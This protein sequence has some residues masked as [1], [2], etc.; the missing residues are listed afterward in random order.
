MAKIRSTVFAWTRIFWVN[1]L[2]L[3][4]SKYWIPSYG[5]I[6]K[7][8]ES[9]SW[10]MIVC[11]KRLPNFGPNWAQIA[12][13]Q[14]NRISGE[15]DQ[16]YYCLPIV[17]YHAKMFQKTSWDTTLNNF[18]PN[19]GQIGHNCPFA[20]KDIFW[21]N[22]LILLSTYLALLCYIVSKKMLTVEQIMRHK[23]SQIWAKLGSNCPFP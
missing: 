4:W 16:C 13:L 14:Q 2:K 23:V 20:W 7:I 18:G 22:W 6:L 21:E 8:L 15:T 17:S 1:W 19:W 5:N 11:D 9:I 10:D 3:L 12:Q